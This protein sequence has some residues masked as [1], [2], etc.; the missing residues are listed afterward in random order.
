MF[1]NLKCRILF[2]VY[3]DYFKNSLVFGWFLF[4]WWI[5]GIFVV[6][7]FI[8]K[9]LYFRRLCVYIWSEREKMFECWVRSIDIDIGIGND[10][11]CLFIKI[12][13]FVGKNYNVN[14]LV[15]IGEKYEINFV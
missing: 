14:F 13:L 6:Y 10:W 11:R 4:F 12:S 8:I 9:Y 3:F 2:Y 5:K 15:K 1:L 7:Y